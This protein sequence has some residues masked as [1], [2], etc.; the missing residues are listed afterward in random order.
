MKNSVSCL[1]QIPPARRKEYVWLRKQNCKANVK[2]APSELCKIN[3]PRV[4]PD[5][6]LAALS[7][8]PNN[9]DARI[10][11]LVMQTKPNHWRRC[12]VSLLGL[13]LVAAVPGSVLAQ[14]NETAV[15]AK[16]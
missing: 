14:T 8:I 11:Y 7:G 4:A 1:E 5:P 3:L 16:T 2:K 9:L 12:F 13:A 6:L 15:P 10:T